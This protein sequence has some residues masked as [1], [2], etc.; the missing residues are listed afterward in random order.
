MPPDARRAARVILLDPADRV[1]LLRAT[2]ESGRISWVVPGGGVRP[3]ETFESAATREVAEET[4]L[5]VNVG[6]CVWTRHRVFA[7]K[8]D[9]ASQYERFFAARCDGRVRATSDRNGVAREHRWWTMEEIEESSDEFAPSGLAELLRSIVAGSL[10]FGPM[11]QDSTEQ[12]PTEQDS[13]DHDPMDHAPM[14]PFPA[15]QE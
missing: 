11:D 4:G 9:V 15:D 7:W 13:I 5:S 14:D 6:R 8:G 12:D 2:A 10:P 1:L 3:W